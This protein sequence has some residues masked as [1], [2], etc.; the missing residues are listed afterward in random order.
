MADQR[1]CSLSYEPLS[2]KLTETACMVANI[3]IPDIKRTE[4]IPVFGTKEKAPQ[5]FR[6]KERKEFVTFTVTYVPLNNDAG[7]A[8]LP[9]V[10]EI[11]DSVLTDKFT[12]SVAVI[13]ILRNGETERTININDCIIKRGSI[14]ID[15]N[16]F[17]H[18]VFEISGIYAGE[19]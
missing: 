1:S 15:I 18:L 14:V 5:N 17:L 2:S 13:N 19:Y 7:K 12:P 11:V 4:I 6:T 3:Q 10:K 9:A 16:D 8:T